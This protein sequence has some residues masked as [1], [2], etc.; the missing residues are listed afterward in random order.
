M[1]LKRVHAWFERT[2]TRLLALEAV[3][4]SLEEWERLKAIASDH[5]RMLAELISLRLRLSNA[6]RRIAKLE[7]QVSNLTAANRN[8][9]TL[10]DAHQRRAAKAEQERAEERAQLGADLSELIG[11]RDEKQRLLEK[12]TTRRQEAEALLHNLVM[13]TQQGGY[14]TACGAALS[15][16]S[17]ARFVAAGVVAATQGCRAVA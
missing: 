3:V 16:C 8:A 9:M 12:E 4:V 17:C 2:K 14:C 10:I 7:T 5:Y 1:N 13:A 6:E 15:T 11:D